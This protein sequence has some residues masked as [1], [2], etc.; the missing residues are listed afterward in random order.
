MPAPA[1][2]PSD[3]PEQR[4]RPPGEQEGHARPWPAG[5]SAAH[6]A[7]SSDQ[8]IGAKGFGRGGCA[9]A[10][11]RRLEH[12]PERWRGRGP[13][14]RAVGCAPDNA[15]WVEIPTLT[16]RPEGGEVFPNGN[17]SFSP[18]VIDLAMASRWFP[19]YAREDRGDRR[20]TVGHEKREEPRGVVG[21]QPDSLCTERRDVV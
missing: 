7:R 9:V 19:A 18:F 17:C 8:P 12:P 6:Q 1:A 14:H 4:G 11:R 16:G 2:R 10:S 5:T 3:A 21:G 20:N 15:R 13:D